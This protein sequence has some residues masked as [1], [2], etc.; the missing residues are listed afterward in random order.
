MGAALIARSARF[1]LGGFLAFALAH[2]ACDFV[3]DYGLSALSFKGGQ[4]LG[5]PCQRGVFLVCGV[6]LMLFGG[7]FV[8]DGARTLLR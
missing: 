2:W 6:C 1:G 5:P 8:F 7:R 4:V 3:W